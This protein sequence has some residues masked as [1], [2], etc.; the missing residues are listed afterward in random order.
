MKN[1]VLLALLGYFATSEMSVNAIT[2]RSYEDPKV[3]EKKDEKKE[4]TKDEKKDDEKKEDKKDEKK[5][6]EKK[7]AKEDDIE[8]SAHGIDDAEAEV[9]KSHEKNAG[10]SAHQI[11]AE[12][13]VKGQKEGDSHLKEEDAMNNGIKKEI[14]DKK[15]AFEESERK[16]IF[17]DPTTNN[18]N[19]NGDHETAN[20]PQKTLDREHGDLEHGPN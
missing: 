6:E 5:E 16:R 1:L 11:Q 10:K 15:K 4:D 13:K 8:K 20:M 17:Y 9:K 14:E 2:I 3:E 7:H 12:E 19:T 18:V